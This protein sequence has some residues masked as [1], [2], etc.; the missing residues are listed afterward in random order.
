VTL[1]KK[2]PGTR[3]LIRAWVFLLSFAFS[4]A[5]AADGTLVIVGGALK[6]DN[7]NVYRAFIDAALPAGPVVIIPAASGQ[8]SRSANGFA[9]DLVSHGFDRERISIFPLAMKDDSTTENV[10]E[11]LWLNNAWSREQL[12]KIVNAAGFWFTGGDQTRITTMLIGEKGEE[13]PLLTLLR[14]RLADGAVI[15]GSS[16]G[17]AIMSREMIAGGD[18]FRALL[19]PLAGEYNSIEEQDSGRLHMSRGL[20]FMPTGIVDQHFDRKARLGRLVRAMAATGQ[21]RAY[22]VDENTAL[23]VNLESGEARALGSGSV[24]LINATDAQFGFGKKQLVS[25]LELSVIAG[26]TSFRLVD[27]EVVSGQGKPT[28]GNEYFGYAPIQ[29]GGMAFSNSRLDQALGYDLLD[30][31]NSTRLKRFSVDQQ[32]RILVYIFTQTP[33]SNGYWRREGSGERYTLS[34]VRF[35]ILNPQRLR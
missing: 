16:A 13:S 24:T 17:A 25:G 20:G 29:G 31:D 19:E 27:F 10:D 21:A 4:S 23:V 3:V 30:N 34:R 7:A 12:D 22:G 14:K 26:G 32:G 1:I 11:S 15:G 33:G 5:T 9:D 35:D 18:S 28:V 8:P 6:T 2:M